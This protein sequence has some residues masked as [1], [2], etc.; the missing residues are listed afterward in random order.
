MHNRKMRNYNVLIPVMLAE[1]MEGVKIA[2]EAG[3]SDENMILDPGIG[4]G[5]SYEDNLAVMNKLEVFSGLGF[6][7]LLA[8]S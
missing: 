5:K 2:A 3:V 1:L 8:T 7:L 6:L 4:F